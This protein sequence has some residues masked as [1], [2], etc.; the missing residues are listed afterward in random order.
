MLKLTVY[1]QDYP[2]VYVAPR[3]I[4][5]LKPYANYTALEV[6]NGWNYCVIET[7]EQILAM[8]EMQEVVV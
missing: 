1:N 3:H 7:P 4:V 6:S 2:F 8:P 5:S